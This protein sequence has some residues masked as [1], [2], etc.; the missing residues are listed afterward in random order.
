MG[1][2]RR[3]PGASEGG[4]CR[5]CLT[6]EVSIG[7]LRSG[8]R[9]HQIVETRRVF[10]WLAVEE[11]GYSG[12]RSCQPTGSLYICDV[13]RGQKRNKGVIQHSQERPPNLPFFMRS[14]KKRPLH[15]NW[16]LNKYGPWQQR[17]LIWLSKWK[18]TSIR[19][20]RVSESK[21][22]NWVEFNAGHSATI[23]RLCH[24]RRSI[25]TT[26]DLLYLWDRAPESKFE[27]NQAKVAR[28]WREMKGIVWMTRFTRL[29]L[30]IIAYSI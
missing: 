30:T 14:V 7:K 1:S 8:S 6:H 23:A 24:N 29:G 20:D 3:G 27:V 16:I 4:S 2:E 21:S 25:I 13:W 10:S 9:R 22:N 5:N 12:G 28:R 17:H 11:L 19:I 15:L 26:R 18:W